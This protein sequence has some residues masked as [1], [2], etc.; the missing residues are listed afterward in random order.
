LITI[1]FLSPPERYRYGIR[2]TKAPQ[3]KLK[4]PY[5]MLS[6]RKFDT[7]SKLYVI[8]NKK[9]RF[10]NFKGIHATKFFEAVLIKG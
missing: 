5:S 9:R 8:K 1:G 4:P 10:R 6:I 2:I 7:K 3:K